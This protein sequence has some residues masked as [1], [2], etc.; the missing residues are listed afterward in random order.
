MASQETHLLSTARFDVVEV[1]AIVGKPNGKTRQIVRHPGA[2]TI[3]PLVDEDHVC[4]I[5]NYRVSVNEV[6]IEL[7]AGTREPEEEAIIT[8][9]RE[10]I[11]ET[12]Y[13]CKNLEFLHGFL[14]SPGILDEQMYLYVA[15]GLTAGAPAREEGEE[16]DNLVVTWQQAIDW[17]FSGEIKDAKT[18]TGLLMFNHLRKN[19]ERN[20]HV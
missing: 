6:L 4:L 12:G 3:I 15:T 19:R 7:P 11:E 16:I 14:L 13:R 9:E 5:N 18:I 2:V 17:V 8:A 1:P 20:I 10:L